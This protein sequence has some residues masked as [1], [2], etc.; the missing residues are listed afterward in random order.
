MEPE[1]KLIQRIARAVPSEIGARR[2]SERAR[3]GLRL[4]IG[5][6][7]AVLA[8]S[9]RTEWVLSC[10][11][12]LEGVHFLAN[13]HPAD[14]V[15]YK[16]LARATSDLA[17]MGASPRYFLLALALPLARTG[18]WL[19]GF[20]RGMAKA[21]RHLGIRLIGGDTK[22]HAS[23]AISITVL[24][25]IPPGLAVTRAGARP[26]DIIYVSGKLGAAQLGLLMLKNDRNLAL[27]RGLRARSSPLHAHLYPQIRVALGSWLARNRVASAMMDISDGLSTDLLRLCEASQ[28]GA[29]IWADRIPCARIPSR[30]GKLVGRKALDPLDLALNGGDDYELLFTVSP[31]NVKKLRRAPGFSEITAIGEIK[32]GNAVMLHHPKSRQKRITSG[33]WDPFRAT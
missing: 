20:L 21:S 31:K 13:R 8:P 14:S 26:G 27:K 7:G 28:V 22:R 9:G 25:E 29:D 18:D 11:A 6:D 30:L 3:G 16:S 4:G 5:N 24:G 17:A 10:D 23:V 12:F 1:T 32:R 19:D 15:G 2:G 33:G